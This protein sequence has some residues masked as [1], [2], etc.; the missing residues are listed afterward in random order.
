VTDDVG[1][2]WVSKSI[3][4]ITS[5]RSIV[6]GMKLI[7]KMCLF[8]VEVPKLIL[9]L[10]SLITGVVFPNHHHFGV[11]LSESIGN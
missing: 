4:T 2:I 11:D 6:T 7:G 8:N 3:L 10:S 5:K 1:V 9:K